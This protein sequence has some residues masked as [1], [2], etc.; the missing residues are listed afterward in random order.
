LQPLRGGQEQRRRSR[1]F[2]A[3]EAERVAKRAQWLAEW[4]KRAAAEEWQER[5][6]QAWAR[7]DGAP[8]THTW[9]ERPAGWAPTDEEAATHRLDPDVVAAL[10][11]EARALDVAAA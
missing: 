10:R 11:D 7:V 3:E 2:W 8:V 9:R 6:R 1:A 5:L 4:E